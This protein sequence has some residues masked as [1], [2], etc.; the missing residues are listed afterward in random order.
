MNLYAYVNNTPSMLV[1]PY[2]LT[3][4]KSDLIAA[5]WDTYGDKWTG[6]LMWY[7]DAVSNIPAGQTHGWLWCPNSAAYK[8]CNHHFWYLADGSTEWRRHESRDEAYSDRSRATPTDEPISDRAMTAAQRARLE[9][10]INSGGLNLGIDWSKIPSPDELIRIANQVH[11]GFEVLMRNMAFLGELV[12]DGVSLSDSDMALFAGALEQ[13]YADYMGAVGNTM[14]TAGLFMDDQWW[15]SQGDVDAFSR[16]MGLTNSQALSS[17]GNEELSAEMMAAI[18]DLQAG[19]Q[20]AADRMD[21]FYQTAVWTD[22]GCMA[23][24]LATGL[25]ALAVEGAKI[26]GKEGL[27]FVL[28]EVAIAAVR[29]AAAAGVEYVG[30]DLAEAMGVDP[31]YL[32]VA[33]QA[34]NVYNGFKMAGAARASA[35][36]RNSGSSSGS[37]TSGSSGAGSKGSAGT[38]AAGVCFVAGTRI[39]TPEGTREIEDIRVGDRVLTTDAGLPDSD[40]SDSDPSDRIVPR[41]WRKVTLRMPN[42]LGRQDIL[43][44]VVLRPVTWIDRTDCRVGGAMEFELAE[45]GLRGPATVVS[46]EPCPAIRPGDGRVVLATV[47]HLN[48]ELLELTLE[49]TSEPLSPTATHWLYSEDRGRWIPAGE[50]RLGER[51][52]TRQGPRA[53]TRIEKQPGGHR[54][55]NLE[56]QT[57]HSYYVGEVGVLSHNVNPCAQPASSNRPANMTPEGAGR[58][59]ALRQAKRDNGIPT[60]QQPDSVLP[61]VDRRGQVQPGRVYEYDVPAQGGGSQ[62]VRIRDD[63][64]GHNYGSGNSQNRG[65]HFNGE[66]GGHYDY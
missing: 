62:R 23:V 21:L 19:T 14:I 25:G 54:V 15:V 32:H 33:S 29:S 38:A 53:I 30:G 49:Q 16:A 24:G 27:K 64:A 7:S 11:G 9:A 66:S 1:D 39:H 20:S 45:M 12:S 40:H 10:I 55:Y 44:I 65:S 48:N 42:P 31:H 58:R 5:I 18:I 34:I 51:L 41:D 28:K 17:L 3:G 37:G 43:D 59:G 36:A 2:G 60:S 61:N 56:V 22:R 4:T 35:K 13:Q 50:L 47:T 6:T 46:V 57:R 26:G 52:R 63:A 8:E